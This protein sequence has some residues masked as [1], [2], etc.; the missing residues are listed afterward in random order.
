MPRMMEVDLRAV[1]RLAFFGVRR[2]VGRVRPT[3]FF[4]RLLV[5][6]RAML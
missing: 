4:A 6:D 5:A 2:K 1:V 3:L